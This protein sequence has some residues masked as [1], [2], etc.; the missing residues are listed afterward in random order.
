MS[1][2]ARLADEILSVLPSVMEALQ[3]VA[4][5]GTEHVL[6]E[7]LSRRIKQNCQKMTKRWSA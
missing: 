3:E 2:G 5:P 7:R 6:L 1:L 4:T